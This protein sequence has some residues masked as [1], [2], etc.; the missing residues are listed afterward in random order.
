MTRLIT[1]VIFLTALIAFTGCVATKKYDAAADEATRYQGEVVTLTEMLNRANEELA[2]M[3]VERDSL[4]Q[5]SQ[6]LTIQLEKLTADLANSQA[7]NNTLS[8]ALQATSVEKDAII[9]RLTNEKQAVEDSLTNTNASVMT[10]RNDID[11]IQRELDALKQEKEVEL[12]RQQADYESLMQAL[13]GEIARGELTI[14]SLQ[15]RLSVTIVDRILFRS[16]EAIIQESGLAVLDR[17]GSALAKLKG[18]RIVIEGHTDNVAIGPRLRLIYPTNW[19]LSTARAT[20]VARYLIDNCGVDENNISV[21]GYAYTRPV[22]TN[23]TEEGR[24]QNRRIEILLL[25]Q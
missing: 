15:D 4:L 1:I 18:K 21:A 3:T 20:T 14:I 6:E 11:A 8:S 16:G 25:Q 24:A 19:E 10:L 17:V 23:T 5:L 2:R 7:N 12:A 13:E 22:T 9:A